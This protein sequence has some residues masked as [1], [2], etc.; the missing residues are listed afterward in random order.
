MVY[1]AA[2]FPQGILYPM[3]DAPAPSG[4]LSGNVPLY[5]RPEPLTPEAHGRLGVKPLDKPWSFMRGAHFVPL[6]VAEF[7]LAGRFFPIIFMGENKMPAAVLGL[8]PGENLF[9]D[10]EGDVAGELYIPA[11][12]R[13]WPFVLAQGDNTDQLVVCI[14][15]EAEAVSEHPEVAFFENG[16]LTEFTKN[17]I[18]FCESFETE[19]QRTESFVRLMTTHDIWETKVATFTPRN[20]DGSTGDPVTIADYFGVSEEKLRALPASTL[21]ELRD[22]GAL[23]QMYAHLMSLLNWEALIARAM[24]RQQA[25]NAAPAAGAA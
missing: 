25:L 21:A 14:D 15:R 19:R 3:T 17:A 6:T 8:N 23:N 20:A 11:F 5:K 24:S 16:Q 12:V 2:P 9:V 10:P 22:N 1:R 7:T 18:Q 4:Q 13:R